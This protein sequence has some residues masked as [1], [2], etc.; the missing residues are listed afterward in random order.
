[1]QTINNQLKLFYQQYYN[2]S[3]MKAPEFVNEPGLSNNSLPANTVQTVVPAQIPATPA[4]STN[5]TA[6]IGTSIIQQPVRK[7]Q[8]RDQA[9]G[10]VLRIVGIC[11]LSCAIVIGTLELIERIN[12]DERKKQ[13][14]ASNRI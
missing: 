2:I 1:M 14:K 4:V 3:L 10:K 9:D 7:P 8:V 11:I 12:D 13:R 5:T 6:S